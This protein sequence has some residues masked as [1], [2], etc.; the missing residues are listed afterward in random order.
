MAFTIADIYHIVAIVCIFFGLLSCFAGYRFFRL[1]L[2]LTGFALFFALGFVAV[3]YFITPNI[4]AATI[5]GSVLAT[6][7][8]V[9]VSCFPGFGAFLLG[10]FFGGSFSV[11]FISLVKSTCILY[12]NHTKLRR[13]K[14][15]RKI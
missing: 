10:S 8:S 6:F 5:V 12:F 15:P 7:G 1:L 3:Y 14:I 13:T 9:L 4:I 2:A 11:V